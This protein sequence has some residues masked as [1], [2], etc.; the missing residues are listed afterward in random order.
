MTS[1]DIAA[2]R[3]SKDHWS[4][5]HVAHT[6]IVDNDTTDRAEGEIFASADIAIDPGEH[7]VLAHVA[8]NGDSPLAQCPCVVHVVLDMSGESMPD[9]EFFAVFERRA[10]DGTVHI[11]QSDGALGW[12]GEQ[13]HRIVLREQMPQQRDA[14]VSASTGQRVITL[15]M[16]NTSDSVMSINSSATLCV[17]REVA[18]P[19]L[20]VVPAHSGTAETLDPLGP[21]RVPLIDLVQLGSTP[22]LLMPGTLLLNTGDVLLQTI[23]AIGAFTHDM[24]DNTP[25]LSEQVVMDDSY[26]I[27]VRT[28]ILYADAT[29]AAAYWISPIQTISSVL[30]ALVNPTLLSPRLTPLQTALAV[31]TLQKDVSATPLVVYKPTTMH[32]APTIPRAAS[33][34]PLASIVHI[35]A[36]INEHID[37]SD[38]VGDGTNHAE[39]TCMLIGELSSYPTTILSGRYV[40][41][42]VGAGAPAHV[43]IQIRVFV[44]RGTIFR[45]RA[46]KVRYQD[47]FTDKDGNNQFQSAIG[48]IN[49]TDI[50]SDTETESTSNESFFVRAKHNTTWSIRVETDD[51]FLIGDSI[52][53]R[54][55]CVV[56]RM[57]IP[58][59]WPASMWWDIAC[60][61]EQQYEVRFIPDSPIGRTQFGHA[62][63]M[64]VVCSGAQTPVSR[65]IIAMFQLK[66]GT[67]ERVT[68]AA[69]L[70]SQ[71][72]T[73]PGPIDVFIEKEGGVWEHHPISAIDERTLIKE[74]NEAILT[75]A[76]KRIIFST[77]ANTS[78]F[79]SESLYNHELFF[80]EWMWPSE[81]CVVDRS[82][83]EPLQS[84]HHSYKTSPTRS[85]AM[86][87]LISVSELDQTVRIDVQVSCNPHWCTV[88]MDGT[89]LSS[90]TDDTTP[91]VM[92]RRS[93]WY[94]SP[95]APNI[96]IIVPAGMIRESAR[97]SITTIPNY[98][99][100][101]A[102]SVDPRWSLF[103]D[104][105]NVVECSPRIRCIS[106]TDE[107][108]YETLT[109]QTYI[110]SNTYYR[111][112]QVD[113]TLQESSADHYWTSIAY[114]DGVWIAVARSAAPNDPDGESIYDTGSL[115]MRST[116]GTTWTTM[117]SAENQL[118]NSVV[119]GAGK[120][121][122]VASS[123]L[124]SS[125][126]VMSSTDGTVW[127]SRTSPVDCEWMDVSFGG[128]VFVAVGHGGS[129]VMRSEDGISWEVPIVPVPEGNWN[130][131]AYGNGL[132]VAVASAGKVMTSSDGGNTWTLRDTPEEDQDW[133]SV[134]YGNGLWVAVASSGSRRVMTSPDGSAWTE[135]ESA[136]DSAS[137]S[138]V[139]FGDG[140]WMA[141]AREASG[142]DLIM[143]S[144]DGIH[145]TTQTS[146]HNQWESVAFGNHV[147][148]AVSSTGVGNRVITTPAL[149][150]GALVQSTSD[151]FESTAED[152]AIRTMDG[153]EHIV[154]RASLASVENSFHFPSIQRCAR[155][156]I[157]HYQPVTTV[158]YAASVALEAENLTF[159]GLLHYMRCTMEYPDCD[160][161]RKKIRSIMDVENEYEEENQ[162]R[163]DSGYMTS[164]ENFIFSCID[165][166]VVYRDRVDADAVVPLVPM[167]PLGPLDAFPFIGVRKETTDEALMK[168]FRRACNIYFNANAVLNRSFGRGQD[169]CRVLHAAPSDPH[170]FQTGGSTRSAR[171]SVGPLLVPGGERIAFS[172]DTSTHSY[173]AALASMTVFDAGDE[174]NTTMEDEISYSAAQYASDKRYGT[175]ERTDASS[176]TVDGAFS[177]VAGT[178]TVALNPLAGL[179]SVY[180]VTTLLAPSAT[181]GT[182]TLAVRTTGVQEVV[183]ESSSGGGGD[184]HIAPIDGRPFDL[185]HAVR[186]VRFVDTQRALGSGHRVVINAAATH[187]RSE[188]VGAFVRDTGIP[189][190]DA[191]KMTFWE[192]FY[193]VILADGAIQSHICV[194]ANTLEPRF[195]S[196]RV[197]FDAA[198]TA[199][200]CICV[201]DTD[202]SGTIP[203]FAQDAR[204]T[205]PAAAIVRTLVVRGASEQECMTVR[206]YADL[207]SHVRSAID[208]SIPCAYA[209]QDAGAIGCFFSQR[210]AR[211]IGSVD[212]I[213]PLEDT[214]TE[215]ARA[216]KRVRTVLDDEEE[217][218]LFSFARA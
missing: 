107:M 50:M 21:T 3:R 193:F 158:P 134:A 179:S 133:E 191:M 74:E 41:P 76:G 53:V 172:Y 27:S 138:G 84:L 129:H 90:I 188:E 151:E 202:A 47:N 200:H 120:W 215:G 62:R 156:E 91:Y 66:H 147:F 95:Y 166:V 79:T 85:T 161:T 153:I 165:D 136:N 131:I 33:A 137:W 55:T 109:L 83:G 169:V 121:I 93:S 201:F 157:R 36:G 192:C 2:S 94:S 102:C 101:I 35:D 54:F 25:I 10:A 174:E 117:A 130:A 67:A 124:F 184:P 160:V 44:K 73:N 194:D 110:P 69:R 187:L 70:R 212:C 19:V 64:S 186:A 75:S 185:D 135:T 173:P 26:I 82:T 23:V 171:Y 88:S 203:D 197:T 15:C 148:A 208:I 1:L 140:V 8:M 108:G 49:Y 20:C 45:E 77:A 9:A 103:R 105:W 144:T 149:F 30:S 40:Q 72:P 178:E 207:R 60:I 170:V 213:L 210:W 100:V 99:D 139:A 28:D 142:G 143:S 38:V 22:P 164:Y 128:G 123:G 199:P 167:V 217:E 152:V 48:Y 176:S 98:I 24:T 111:V 146:A 189:R 13:P 16:R 132:W 145:W 80:I 206:L 34:P 204:A 6:L 59:S 68:I 43:P 32:I 119:F 42:D 46:A 57:A 104:V 198:C 61:N 205:C 150:V 125:S 116:N 162:L 18:P 56:R 182:R 87:Q 31:C 218:R 86:E 71:S 163:N 113:W 216:P 180:A 175:L 106:N 112:L 52:H 39:V 181:L 81:L 126:R 7:V 14:S 211:D 190:A 122:A 118:W 92:R 11:Q 168:G 97:I 58:R 154:Q 63:S 177:A 51:D 196:G 115:V 183:F 159:N 78:L 127:T 141:V 65:S 4:L 155:L 29:F 5:G 12:L 96:S 114:G 89:P 17:V 209:L 37:Q 214:V 195:A